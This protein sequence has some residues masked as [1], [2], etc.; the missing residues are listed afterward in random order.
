MLILL[1][2]KLYIYIIHYTVYNTHYASLF[3]NNNKYDSIYLELADILSKMSYATKKRVGALIVKDNSIIAD[4]YNGTPVGYD[5]DCEDENG[6][7]KWYVLHAEANAI[8]K[9]VKSGQSS[10][11][12]TLYIT[13]SPCKECTKLIIQ[14]G[15]KRVVYS[16]KYKD[17]TG[18]H[19]LGNF[20][21]KCEYININGTC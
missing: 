1:K 12:S 11:G 5:N 16:S 3:M 21:I 19:F 17:Q 10:I 2:S 7:T 6:N 20:N 15:I 4:G 13:M 8:T 18:I 9:L 14:S